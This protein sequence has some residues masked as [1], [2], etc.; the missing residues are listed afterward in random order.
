MKHPVG[1]VSLETAWFSRP[2]SPCTTPSYD[3]SESRSTSSRSP[4]QPRSC[5]QGSPQQRFSKDVRK[6]CESFAP[7]QVAHGCWNSTVAWGL[8][9]WPAYCRKQSALM[10]LL[11]DHTVDLTCSQ[12]QILE[13]ELV[14][15]LNNQYS[16]KFRNMGTTQTYWSLHNLKP[17]CWIP[18]SPTIQSWHHLPSGKLTS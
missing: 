13:D 15:P 6:G 17:A 1:I 5:G 8:L 14:K 2:P 4:I 7:V 11:F 18:S 10:K 12:H 3:E 9:G 16:C